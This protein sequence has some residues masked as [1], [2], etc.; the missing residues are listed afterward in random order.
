MLSHLQIVSMH[1]TTLSSLKSQPPPS[2]HQMPVALAVSSISAPTL[3]V[4]GSS[5]FKTLAR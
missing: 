1:I 5:G 2:S 3:S 4:I